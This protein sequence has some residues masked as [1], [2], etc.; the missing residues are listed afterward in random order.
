MRPASTRRQGRANSAWRVI[1]APATTN[2]LAAAEDRDATIVEPHIAA[3]R[4]QHRRGGRGMGVLTVDRAEVVGEEI[5]V[6]DF[7]NLM[8]RAGMHTE[9]SVIFSTPTVFDQRNTFGQRWR[10]QEA[11]DLLDAGKSEPSTSSIVRFS[12]TMCNDRPALRPSYSR[13][14]R[15]GSTWLSPTASASKRS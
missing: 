3:E 10:C 15:N 5:L 9:G 13:C 8:G 7:H 4:E 2:I 1:W 12:T 14:R 11:K 6:R